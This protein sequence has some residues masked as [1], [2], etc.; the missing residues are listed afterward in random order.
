MGCVWST[1]RPG[2]FTP[3]KDPVPIVQDGGL[4]PG[5][6]WTGAENLAPTGIGSPARPA[7]SESLCRLSHPSPRW[8]E[9]VKERRCMEELVM[10][11]ERKVHL[12]Q[13]MKARAGSRRIA[14]L[15]L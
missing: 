10:D 6:V 3:R 9:N 4:A 12:E 15:F 1:P 5:P 8:S 14:L 13:F 2:Q 11:G 7:L